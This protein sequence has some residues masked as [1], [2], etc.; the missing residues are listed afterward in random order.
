M[1]SMKSLESLDLHRNKLF[2]I[3]PQSL[4]NLNFL[5]TL[6]LS[7]NNLSGRI[8]TGD[9]LQTILDSYVYIGNAYLCGFP[10]NKS[11]NPSETSHNDIVENN[12]KDLDE[13]LLYL[14]V[15]IGCGFGFWV[16]F[17]VLMFKRNWR[18]CFFQMVDNMFDRI[19]VFGD[20]IFCQIEEIICV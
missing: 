2:G 20:I 5:D 18:C 1:G 12:D 15:V 7:Y 9:Q 3:I 14:I 16:F 13:V 10:L 6:N 4:A 11:C 8:P 17:G 19:Y